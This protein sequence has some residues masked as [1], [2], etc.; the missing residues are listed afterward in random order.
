[1]GWSLMP[2]KTKLTKEL[3][4]EAEKLLRA[5]NYVSVICNYLGIAESTWYRWMEEG[6]KA[7]SG[8]KREF[9][10]SIKR[11]ESTPEIRSVQ[12]IQQA[13]Q[14][15][16]WKAAMTYLERKFP[17]RWGKRDKVSADVSHSGEVIDRHEQHTT[18]NIKTEL[19]QYNEAIEELFEKGFIE[20]PS[21]N[22]LD[23]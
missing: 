20:S 21:Q 2:R 16:D 10:E 17:D 4:K 19:Q 22:N 5:G 15:G 14:D 9:W 13:A 6:E 8:L 7:R 11:A 18:I 3:M 12:V 23:E 1:M